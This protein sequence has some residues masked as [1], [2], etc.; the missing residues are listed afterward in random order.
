MWITGFDVPSLLDHLPRQADEEPHA[1]ADHRT[2]QPCRA[3]K[4]AGLIVDY[5]GV[6]RDLQKALAIYAAPKVVLPAHTRQSD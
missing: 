5:V 4:V 1:H 3:G 6:F 2:S